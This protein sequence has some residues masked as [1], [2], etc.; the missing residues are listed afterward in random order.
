M[1]KTEENL[2]VQIHFNF[3]NVSNSHP[4]SIFIQHF[5]FHCVH[6]LRYSFIPPNPLSSKLLYSLHLSHPK[7]SGE[8]LPFLWL[9]PQYTPNLPFQFIP[10]TS[11]SAW[12]L[13]QTNFLSYCKYSFWIHA[14]ADRCMWCVLFKY[15]YPRFV[16]NCK[17]GILISANAP[18]QT[19][20]HLPSFKRT[21]TQ[22][23]I[24]LKLKTIK[25]PI[26]ICMH[27]CN[28]N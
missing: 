2:T 7:P 23:N 17:I 3:S 12:T 22:Q 24:Q 1:R 25:R 27:T 16:L 14:T 5:P 9:L 6:L 21:Q 20:F 10:P 11:F 4:R 19:C 15:P 18:S 13:P 28:P 8:V 26:F